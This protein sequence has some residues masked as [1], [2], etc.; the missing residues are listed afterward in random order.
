MRSLRGRF[1][2]SHLLPVL[3]TVPLAGIALFYILET[4]LLLN[5]LEQ[6]LSQQVE[7]VN[8]EIGGRGDIWQDPDQA[9]AFLQSLSRQFQ[10][11]VTLLS[12][13]GQ[14]FS[15]DATP[16]PEGG[17]SPAGVVL[18]STISAQ[19]AVI[20]VPVRDINQE[21][22]GIVQVSREVHDL[23]GRFAGLRW[24]FIGVLLLELLGGSI[25][26]LVL[27]LNLERPIRVLTSAVTDIAAG[28]H[29]EELHIGGPDELRLLARAVNILS[30]R[31]EN[32][33]ETRRHL[34]ANVV[35]EVGRPLG[36]VRSA[37]H[38]LRQ[39]RSQSPA[40]R[41]ELLAGI[42]LELEQLQP[43]LDDLT[44]LHSQNMGARE[45]ALQPLDLNDWLRPHLQFWRAAAQEKGLTWQAALAP[46]LPL[47]R[48][49]PDRLARAV[50]N[51]LSNAIKYT[52]PE[53]KVSVETGRSGGE[54]WLRI[55][56]TGPGIAAED[57]PQLFTPFF[58]GQQ[59]S[60]FPKGLGL[61]LTISQEIVAAHNGRIQVDSALG[62]GSQFVIY[63]PLD[64]QVS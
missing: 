8:T 60:R 39:D 49:D 23:S 34:L 61:G 21:L 30:T 7:L 18:S 54:V 25:I 27:A 45:L 14:P 53:G 4:Q 5:N 40:V 15:S 47:L 2:L 20:Y 29:I 9:E 38:A 22:V 42:D 37:I 28:Q 46:D 44:S 52:Q 50:G 1:L 57:M 11:Q 19:T 51:L 64:T 35:H 32:L 13:S 33:E 16:A 26:G 59:Q 17:S 10:G 6:E 55:G 3:I 24:I 43:L 36:A 63:L 31:L 12:P 56:D 58:R 62:R 41:Q 48:I